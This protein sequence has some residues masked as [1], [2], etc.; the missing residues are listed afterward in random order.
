MSSCIL[1]S[2]FGMGFDEK[3]EVMEQA[4]AGGQVFQRYILRSKL[5]SCLIVLWIPACEIW[6]A[7][8]ICSGPDLVHA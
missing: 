2:H 4:T 5:E 1:I 8:C 7:D 6:L 3:I